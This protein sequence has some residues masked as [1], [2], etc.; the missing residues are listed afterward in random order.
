[1]TKKLE[2]LLNLPDSKEILEESKK[3]K[4]ET[5]I[6]EQEETIR[7]IEELDKIQS[8]LPAVKGLGELADKEL[9][10]VADKAMTAYEDLMDLGMNVESRYSGRVFEVAGG[11]LKTSLDAKVAKVDKKLKMIELQ[12]KKEKLDKD[13]GAETDIVQGEGYVVTDRNSLLEKLKKMDK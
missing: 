13:G 12:L 8:A 5:A 3:E 4:Q 1:M 6:V 10:E 2:D 9:N 11:M 7:S